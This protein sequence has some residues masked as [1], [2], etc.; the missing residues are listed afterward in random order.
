MTKTNK[1]G[2]KPMPAKEKK[3]QVIYYVPQMYVDEFK[4]KVDPIR[5][6]INKKK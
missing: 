1:P 3:V 2:R 5:D 4:G 6:K